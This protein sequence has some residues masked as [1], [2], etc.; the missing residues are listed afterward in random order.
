MEKRV[1]ITGS[2]LISSLGDLPAVVHYALCKGHSGL[3]PVDEGTFE[4][5][6]NRLAGNVRSFSPET[7]LPER[8]FR[9]LDRTGQL[10][11]AATKFALESSG[12]SNERLKEHDVGLVLGTMFGSVHPGALLRKSHGFC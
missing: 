4:Y 8:S 1:A 5:A 11:V 7:Y 2:G 10:V 12:W 9:P 6:I 3:H